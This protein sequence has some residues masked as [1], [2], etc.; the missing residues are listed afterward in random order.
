MPSIEPIDRQNRLNAIV[1]SGRIFAAFWQVDPAIVSRWLAEGM[2]GDRSGIPLQEASWWVQARQSGATT[3][4]VRKL[5]AEAD[6]ACME[7]DQMAGSLIDVAAVHAEW[8]S[9][10]SN[11]RS[12]LLQL[13]A[14]A[15]LRID[16]L[17]TIA[18][19]EAVIKEIVVEALTELSGREASN[20]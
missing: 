14:K 15:A 1:V 2:P 5:T 7:R 17:M 18:E 9:H 16:P 10:I 8:S 11:A 19:R 20:E 13:P 3:D 6:I 12:R 4:K